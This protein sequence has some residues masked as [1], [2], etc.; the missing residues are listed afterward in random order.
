MALYDEHHEQMTQLVQFYQEDQV[1]MI[2]HKNGSIFPAD[3]SDQLSVERLSKYKALVKE[4]G[5]TRSLGGSVEGFVTLQI[6]NLI[7]LS[8]MKTL[9]YSPMPP[10][11]I[12]F[13]NTE[14][15]RFSP[16][17][18]RRVCRPIEADWYICLDY[19]D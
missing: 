4:I 19:E 7:P 2:V 1:G 15:Y 12:T 9:D 16:A 18:Y 14:D 3:T 13:G 5:V 6:F 11:L 17:Q 8:P 10:T